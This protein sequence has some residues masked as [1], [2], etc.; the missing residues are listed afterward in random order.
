MNYEEITEIDKTAWSTRLSLSEPWVTEPD[1]ATWMDDT[2]GLRCF[3][4]RNGIGCWCG[5]VTYDGVL[6]DDQDSFSV[7]GGVTY[8][9]TQTPTKLAVKFERGQR[10]IGFDCGHNADFWPGYAAR[11]GNDV[12]LFAGSTYKNLKYVIS[13]TEKLAKQVHQAGGR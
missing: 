13:E 10:C 2:T 5:Y 9:E 7:H 8:H 12:S 4:K 1:F 6:S 11:H 3:A